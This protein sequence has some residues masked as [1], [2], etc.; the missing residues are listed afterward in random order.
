M[1]L[2]LEQQ[3]HEARIQAAAESLGR[4]IDRPER[5][6]FKVELYRLLGERDAAVVDELERNRMARA[7]R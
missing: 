3:V 6:R 1:R 7:K 4:A 2:T 5:K